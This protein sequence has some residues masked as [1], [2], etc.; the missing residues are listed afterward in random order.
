MLLRF[1]AHR[2]SLK[3][4][5]ALLSFVVL[6]KTADAQNVRLR[7]D[8]LSNNTVVADQYLNLYGV[9][10]RSG[11]T[12][13]PVHTW[14]TCGASCF[15]TSAPNFITTLPDTSGVVTVEFQY[16]VSG[17]TFYMIGVDAFFNQ[18]AMIDVYR[19]GAF[20]A[21]Y[22]VFGNGNFTVGFTFGSLDNIS[23]IVIRG[24]TD[25]SGI[26]FDDFSFT[27]P[28][29]I[30]ITSSRIAGFLNQSTQNA[31]LGANVTLLA[32]PLPTG[33]S[34]GTYAWTFTGPSFVLSGAN[35]SAVTFRSTDLGTITAA[36]AYTKD[37]VTKSAPVTI[38]AILPTLSSFTA[39]QGRDLVSH[40]N[41]NEQDS[42]WWYRLG[43]IPPQDPGIHFTA[44]VQTP[45]L[46]SDPSQSGV[47]YVQ[48]VSAL[49]KRNLGRPPDAWGWDG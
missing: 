4:V 27:V 37:G 25:P 38:N 14:Q 15:P 48:A 49:R 19:N 5:L 32:T 13:F 7:F 18:F 3:M 29:E 17:L 47:K 31:L 39:Q 6:S 21:T 42:F 10:F 43:C 1:L 11:N 46:I 20:Y 30:K 44:T 24:I 41:C 16:P 40:Q 8:E 28:W 12:S 22:P 45:T 26:G 9:R 2:I 34:G 23:K 33:F 36:I 35:S